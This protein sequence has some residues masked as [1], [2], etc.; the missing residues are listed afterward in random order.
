MKLRCRE[1]DLALIT[2]DEPGCEG[3]I[4]RLVTVYGPVVAYAIRGPSWHIEPVQPAP[5]FYAFEG[6]EGSVHRETVVLQDG[7]Y[8]PDKWLLP[9]RPGLDCGEAGEEI[10]ETSPMDIDE[11]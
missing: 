3:N 1:G 10:E 5:Y 4:G 11:R 9:L 2:N 7:V 8:H 6:D